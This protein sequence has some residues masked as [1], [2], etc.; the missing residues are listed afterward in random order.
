MPK[1]QG[2]YTIVV[3]IK[4]STVPI[5]TVGGSFTFLATSDEGRAMAVEQIRLAV[6]AKVKDKTSDELT[7][8][9]I[10]LQLLLSLD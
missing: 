1:F 2:F 10:S 6:I 3:T 4:D 8:H 7:G 5:S 9:F